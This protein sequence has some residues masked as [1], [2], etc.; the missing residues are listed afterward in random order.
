MNAMMMKATKTS[1]VIREYDPDNT[2]INGIH[3]HVIYECHN[4]GNLVNMS[5]EM[6]D[7]IPSMAS[8]LLVKG[9]CIWCAPIEEQKEDFKLLYNLKSNKL[10]SKVL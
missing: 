9:Y 2:D 3:V 8:H 6:M 10:N 4:C 5:T 7:Q 1:F